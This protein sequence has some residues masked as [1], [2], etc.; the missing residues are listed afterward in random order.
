MAGCS[1]GY[2]FQLAESKLANEEIER[3]GIPRS[4]SVCHLGILPAW[5]GSD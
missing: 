5:Y 3:G 1:L 4:S 2:A